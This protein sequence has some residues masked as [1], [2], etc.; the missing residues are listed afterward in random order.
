MVLDRILTKTAVRFLAK[1]HKFTTDYMLE[2]H[3]G[4]PGWFDDIY[5]NVPINNAFK[6]NSELINDILELFPDIFLKDY[7]IMSF[8]DAYGQMFEA[9]QLLSE[10]M[11]TGP[12]I[13]TPVPNVCDLSFGLHMWD[14]DGFLAS[15]IKIKS[16]ES[17]LYDVSESVKYNLD[18][19]RKIFNEYGVVYDGT[20]AYIQQGRLDDIVRC[21]R[22]L[23]EYIEVSKIR[24]EIIGDEVL[25]TFYYDLYSSS[26]SNYLKKESLRKI[27]N[28]ELKKENDIEHN[29]FLSY[30][31]YP[32][33]KSQE[34]VQTSL[35][36]IDEY[37]P[38]KSYELRDS[39]GNIT[40]YIVY[41]SREKYDSNVD[42]F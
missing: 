13:W 15:D 24:P 30:I 27:I 17:I 20:K 14:Y 11:F 7:K 10:M 6:R 41:D 1:E 42:L 32:S 2:Y 26:S 23:S 29:V 28:Q 3:P 33:E 25:Y 12:L 38:A 16:N 37:M 36:I 31:L 39:D 19:S 22:Q 18:L 21:N 5:I 9:H 35:S 8:C 34:Y 4:F 40:V